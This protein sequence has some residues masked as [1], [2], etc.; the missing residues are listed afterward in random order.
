MIL[1]VFLDTAIYSAMF[2][3][4]FT[5]PRRI[6]MSETKSSMPAF[7]PKTRYMIQYCHDPS[8]PPNSN[9]ANLAMKCFNNFLSMVWFITFDS[10]AKKA[11]L[12]DR[13]RIIK[14]A[15]V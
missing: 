3:Y 1:N 9:A 15:K 13:L 4:P 7:D 8:I 5:R 14:V 12:A 6:T 11:M 10:E 2:E